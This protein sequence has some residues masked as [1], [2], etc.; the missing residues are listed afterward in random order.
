MFIDDLLFGGPTTLTECIVIHRIISSFG[1]A[2]GLCINGPKS[3][4]IH[5]GNAYSVMEDIRLHLGVVV[6]HLDDG[7]T[8]MGFILKPNNYCNK[9]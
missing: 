3:L 1:R 6:R 2:L 4:L 9:D 5:N 8:Y 7:C